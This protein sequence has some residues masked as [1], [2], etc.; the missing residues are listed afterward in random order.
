MKKYKRSAIYI[1][2]TSI[3]LNIPLAYAEDV[4][5]LDKEVTE[6]VV[7]NDVGLIPTE[8]VDSVFG[9]DKTIEET[10]RAVTSITNETIERFGLFDIDDL[11]VLSP[12]VFTQSFF[13]VAGSLDVR[14]TPGE[15]YFRGMRRLDNP[16][17]Y[18][19]PI[20]ASDSIHIVRGPASPI[21]GP[22]KIGGYLD[23]IPKSSRAETGKY[24]EKDT[25]EISY[26][27]GSWNKNILSGE[28]GGPMN[29]VG[30]RQAGYYVY[31]ET[32]NSDSYYN[33]TATDQNIFQGSFN[34][35]LTDS[36]RVE[37]GGMYHK[38]EGNQVAG[39]NRLTQELIDHGT[40][41]TG[42]AKPLDTN[43]DGSISHQEYNAGA[44][45]DG[46]SQFF[47]RPEFVTDADVPDDFLL[48]NQGTAKLD[49]SQVLVAE[50]D[51]LVNKD[52]VAYFD[53]IHDINDKWSITNKAYYES[54]DNLNENAYGFAQFHD[55]YVVEDKIIIKYTDE[56]DLMKTSFQ[57][58]PSV[59][60]TDFKHGDDFANEF[61]DRRD[62][63]GPSTALDRRLLSTRCNC[64][65]STYLE[66][67]YIDYGLA[68]LADIEFNNGIGLLAG[69]RQD[70]ID[71][72][73]EDKTAILLD[74]S[75]SNG[76]VSD[77]DTG[78]SWTLSAN[79][80]TPWGITPYVTA[81]EQYTIIAGQGAEVNTGTILADGYTDTSE[82]KEIGIKGNLLDGRLFFALAHYKQERTDFSAQSIVTNQSTETKGTEFELRFLAT[83][84]LSLAAA[85]TNIEITNLDTLE[86]GGRFSF[87]GADD[88]TSL[89][90][91]TST[92][93]GQFIGIPALGP[94]GAQKAG[95][96][97]NS[98]SVSG[99]YDF[100][101]GLVT[102]V[103]WFHA[104]EVYSGHSGA[105]ELPE[106][107]LINIGAT[108]S[109]KKWNFSA[110]IR[111]VTDEEYYRANFAS[112]FGSQIVLP[113][114]PRN[115]TVT[116]TY[117]F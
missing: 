49:G 42:T 92:Y 90:N 39:W 53:I 32:E 114:L 3:L 110:M 41:T 91:P 68:F 60:Y 13:G 63:T 10:P 44:G 38:Y 14:G 22:A 84:K 61:F 75:S 21:M 18:P 15:T 113:E 79:Y 76:K 5:E 17:N 47:F 58:S 101:N 88:L 67:D 16:G 27:L 34:I 12:G 108:Y 71:V 8:P 69:V 89:S 57:I 19:T 74:P 48:E 25:G 81:A 1:A 73:S 37:F 93:G 30:D 87:F 56:T 94:G 24:L 117:K 66:G 29:I 83:D 45:G 20:G 106:Y 23:F 107:D 97:E 52:Y 64:D 111:N 59:R 7:E 95:V 46:M 40:Y 116:A 31:F 62:L 72:T 50:D 112:L 109:T 103:S 35:E 36:T 51:Q 100:K 54:Y 70:Y 77:T 9:F 104:D 78:T 115:Y 55:S 4:V 43:G 6:D 26:T 2:V 105:V 85:F 82:L 33:N 11:V 28:I 65:Y 80:K 96:P 102:T 98:Y 86:N 99:S